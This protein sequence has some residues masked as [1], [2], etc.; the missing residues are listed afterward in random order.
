MVEAQ[1]NLIDELNNA[2]AANNVGRRAEMLRHVADLYVAGSAQLASDQ[3]ALFDDVMGRLIAEIDTAARAAFG[4]RLIEMP[5]APPNVL[6]SLALDDTIAVSGPI[7]TKSEQLSEAVVVQAAN[8]KSQDHLLAISRRSSIPETVTDVLV[9]RGNRQVVLSVASNNGAKFSEHGYSTLV[10]RAGTED[11]LALCIWLRPEI[12]RQ[13]LLKLFADAS[14]TVR[15]RLEAADPRRGKTIRE[16]VAQASNRLQNAARA[17]C[18]DHAAILARVK[19]MHAAGELGE[20][21]VA[22]FAKD[23]KFD[24]TAIALAMLSGLSINLIERIMVQQQYDQII[25]VA[26]AIGLPWPIVKA[27]LAFRADAKT[28]AIQDLEECQSAFVKLTPD[29]AKNALKFYRMREQA[30]THAAAAGETKH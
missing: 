19:S 27:I 17:R 12:P 15:A 8:T 13:H 9:G 3:I 11:G 6:R 14:E 18:P 24:A 25:V 21:Q 30:K 16:V 26:R 4:Q 7:L 10:T 20:M 28:G 5:Y 23:G 22:A 2:V 1:R 29:L